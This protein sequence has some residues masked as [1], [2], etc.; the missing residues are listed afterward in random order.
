MKAATM[1]IEELDVKTWLAKSVEEYSTR[2]IKLDLWLGP[3][4][5][6]PIVAGLFADYT[7]KSIS[8]ETDHVF[9]YG[10]EPRNDYYYNV[11]A[12]VNAPA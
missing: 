11:K 8:I 2:E 3:E 9:I 6:A 5:V 4:E 10:Q 7:V 12:T 1:P